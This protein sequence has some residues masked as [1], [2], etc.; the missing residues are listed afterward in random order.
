M[1]LYNMLFGVNGLSELA[2]ELI[3]NP[4]IPRF[5]DARAF[6]I[7]DKCFVEVYTRTGGSNRSSYSEEIHCLQSHPLYN[8]DEDDDYD[9]TYMTFYFQ[10]VDEGD[11]KRARE[12]VD[13]IVA[14]AD[15]LTEEA[16]K[17]EAL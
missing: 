16:K 6:F 1:S 5:R 17:E 4:E 13:A 10:I 14:E 7:G 9:N 2:L 8:S 11:I 12:A 3:G 15:R